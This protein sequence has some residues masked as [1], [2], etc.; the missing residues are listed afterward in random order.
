MPKNP[1]INSNHLPYHVTNRTID[2]ESFPIELNELWNLIQESL[3]ESSK[4][5]PIEIISLVLMS[6]HYHMILITPERNLEEFI[7]DFNMR[8]ESKIVD[9][10]GLATRIFENHFRWQLIQSQQYFMNCYKYVYQNPVRAGL[11]KYCEDYP[12][13]TIRSLVKNTKFSVQVHDRYGFKD[14]FGLKWVNRKVSEEE[15]GWEERRFRKEEF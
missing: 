2:Q 10:V 4:K 12:F 7:S 3:R 9:K 15:M 13:S 5:Y 14:E 6:N 8:V 11:V 1:L